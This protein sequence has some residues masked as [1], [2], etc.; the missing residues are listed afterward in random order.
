MPADGKMGEILPE[1]IV[2]RKLTLATT[3]YTVAIARMAAGGELKRA[4]TK[5]S[6]APEEFIFH[7]PPPKLKNNIFYDLTCSSRP[8]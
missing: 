2:T 1:G 6:L 8:P 4:G 7:Q 5:Y 3:A